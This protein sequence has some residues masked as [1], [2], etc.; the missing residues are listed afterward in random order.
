MFL[1]LKDVNYTNETSIA[2]GLIRKKIKKIHLKKSPHISSLKIA[3]KEKKKIK[4]KRD[5]E[6]FNGVN[7]MEKRKVRILIKFHFM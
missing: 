4:A 3:L 2:A 6:I 5:R 1:I 7:E